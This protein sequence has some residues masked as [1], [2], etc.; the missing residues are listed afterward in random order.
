MTDP[1]LVNLRFRVLGVLATI[2]QNAFLSDRGISDFVVHLNATLPKSA[3]GSKFASCRSAVARMADEQ[4]RRL[5]WV[6]VWAP[7]GV[8]LE[9]AVGVG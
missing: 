8:S 4:R 9:S 6:D 1:Q 7:K 3:L 2:A 5:R